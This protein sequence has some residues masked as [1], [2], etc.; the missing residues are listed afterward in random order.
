MFVL[1]SFLLGIHL[2][3]HLEAENWAVKIL[4]MSRMTVLMIICFYVKSTSL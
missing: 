1:I 3:P 2:W 4:G